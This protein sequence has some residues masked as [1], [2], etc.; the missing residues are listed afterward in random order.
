[1]KTSA[2]RKKS[3]KDFRTIMK[4]FFFLFIQA[5]D[6]IVI[7]NRENNL[8][9]HKKVNFFQIIQNDDVST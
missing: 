9:K 1:M 5:E 2:Q 6:S 4:D 3:I 8:K 7:I